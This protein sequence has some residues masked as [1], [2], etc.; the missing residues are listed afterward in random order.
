MPGMADEHRAAGLL[1]INLGTPDSPRP[2][3]V[4]RYL[5]EFLSDPRVIDLAPWQRKLLLEL[6]ILPF[7]PRRSGEAYAKIWTSD[8][9][10]LLIHGRGL[11]DGVRRRLPGVPVELGMRYGNPSIASALTRLREA[12]VEQIVVFP[13]YP[14]YSAAATASSLDKVYEEACRLWDVPAL[15]VVPPFFDHPGFLDCCAELARPHLERVDPEVVFFSF[16]GLPERQIR[17]SDRGRGHCLVAEDC[18]ERIGEANRM[19]YR[20]QCFATARLLADRLRVPADRRQVCFQSRLGRDPWIKPYTDRLLDELPRRGVRRAVILAPAFVADCLE[21]LEE[22]G[23]RAVEQWRAAGGETLDVVPCLNTHEG[24][25]DAVVA[26]AR[27]T[28][29]WLGAL[30]DVPRSAADAGALSPVRD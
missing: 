26:I 2:G 4:R 19:C 14:Q 18:C 1:L 10:P 8:G 25:F 13:L 23:L 20:A 27:E 15:T 16:H 12:G 28:A 5:R 30:A 22:L 21:T 17:K 6:V 7:R 9:S 24:W 29:P 11:E 3:D